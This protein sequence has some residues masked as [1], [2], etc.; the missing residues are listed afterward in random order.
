M[1]LVRVRGGA[2]KHSSTELHFH[3]CICNQDEGTGSKSGYS[4]LWI[5]TARWSTQME[6]QN[7]E[8]GLELIRLTV[9]KLPLAPPYK[10]HLP[11]LFYVIGWEWDMHEARA[12][13]P[14]STMKG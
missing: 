8:V 11:F 2:D 12:K 6:S 5:F 10:W 9:F 14:S 4:L 1:A 13:R 7:F 3:N